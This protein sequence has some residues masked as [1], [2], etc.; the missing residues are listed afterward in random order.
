MIAA[1]IT[2]FGERDGFVGA[3]KGAALAVNPRLTLVDVSHGVAPGGVLEGALILRSVFAVF[4]EE[5]IFVVVVDPGVGTARRALAARTASRTLVAP[6][7]GLLGPVLEAHAPAAVRSIVEPRFF[8]APPHPTF[9]GRDV[10]ASVAA[11]LSLG[12]PIEALGPEVRDPATIAIPRP[13]PAPGGTGAIEGE[14]LHVDRFGN[15]VTNITPADVA[16][17]GGGPAAFEIGGRVIEGVS[18]TFDGGPALKVIAGS[19][20]FLEVALRGGDAA[21]TLGAG[22]GA[23]VRAT[24]GGVRA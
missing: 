14:V 12:T 22:V 2:D 4:P 7:N 3:M 6:D 16:G 5:T 24:A 20:G 21:R 9:H 15:L 23:R 1:L 13:R 18:A 17:L 8:R 10:F 11:H 19:W